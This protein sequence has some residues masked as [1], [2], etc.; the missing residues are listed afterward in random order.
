[1][2][3]SIALTLRAVLAL[4]ADVAWPGWYT[5]GSTPREEPAQSVGLECRVRVRV[6]QE[7][8]SE[9]TAHLHPDLW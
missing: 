7:R 8:V 9:G 5:S 1:M 2:L 3:V 6:K 4:A